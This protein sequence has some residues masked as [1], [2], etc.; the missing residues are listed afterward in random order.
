[1]YLKI[2][3]EAFLS[4]MAVLGLFTAISVLSA[5]C[6]RRKRILMTVVVWEE[7]DVRSAERLLREAASD[8][9]ACHNGDVAIL[10]SSELAEREEIGRLVACYGVA[11]YVTERK[12]T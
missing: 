9:L 7:R 4:A 5:R 8:V 6:F 10:V 1:M 3:L 12:K 2:F 11:C